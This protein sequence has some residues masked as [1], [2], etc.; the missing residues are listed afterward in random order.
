MIKFK[1]RYSNSVFEYSFNNLLNSN[2]MNVIL[3]PTDFSNCANEAQKVAFSLAK[4]FNAELKIIHVVSDTI[5]KWE[6]EDHFHESISMFPIHSNTTKV[7]IEDNE[8]NNLANSLKKIKKEA[9]DLGIK[10]TTEL[11][12]GDTSRVILEQISKHKAS[13]LVMGTNGASGIKEAF[14]G[15]ITQWITKK[16]ECPVLSIRRLPKKGFKV[17]KIVYASDFKVESEN[18]NL[19]LIKILA[20]YFNA[21]IHL[22]FINTPHYFEESYSC[23]NRIIDVAKKHDLENYKV[24]IYNHYT[25]EDGVINYSEKNDVDIIAVSNHQYGIFKSLIEHRTT[26][27]LINHAKVPVLTLN[28]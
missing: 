28:I 19:E 24:D 23:L 18:K 4:L 26:E 12:F 16:A 10:S 25:V 6:S 15:S 20:S 11:L 14:I 5:F 13:L 3:F 17:E 1:Y 7:I 9:H 8:P 2:V 21:Q 27:A 22:L